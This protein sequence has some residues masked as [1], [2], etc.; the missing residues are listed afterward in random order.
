MLSVFKIADMHLS[1]NE[2]FQ[3]TIK[4]PK[5]LETNSEITR[6]L[7]EIKLDF[8]KL[9]SHSRRIAELLKG[10]KRDLIDNCVIQ[11]KQGGALDVDEEVL[12]PDYHL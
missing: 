10:F 2:D 8:F 4:K 7:E 1:S 11:L 3:T 6:L 5:E 12:L 9:D